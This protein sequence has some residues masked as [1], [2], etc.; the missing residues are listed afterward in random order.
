MLRLLNLDT[1]YGAECGSYIYENL[2]FFSTMAK[3][4]QLYC[5]LL[6]IIYP[7]WHVSYHSCNFLLHRLKTLCFE[8]SESHI[9]MLLYRKRQS[10][11]MIQTLQRKKE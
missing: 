4:V 10:H 1:R 5:W 2:V 7:G 11:R 3:Y 8:N 9:C 6:S